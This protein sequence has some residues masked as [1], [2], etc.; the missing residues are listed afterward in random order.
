MDSPSVVSLL[1]S[2]D[3]FIT[4]G[5]KH[6]EKAENDFKEDQDAILES[7]RQY[8]TKYPRPLV[9]SLMGLYKQVFVDMQVFHREDLDKLFQDPKHDEKTRNKIKEFINFEESV[10]EFFGRVNSILHEISGEVTSQMVQV[11]DNFPTNLE[12][13][14][15][16]SSTKYKTDASLFLTDDVTKGCISNDIKHCIVVLLRH[17][18]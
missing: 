3:K 9:G 2:L 12:V 6:K 18:S 8:G 14:D 4:E 5:K 17:F 16:R 13:E 15:V 1:T 10:D 7:F 11:N